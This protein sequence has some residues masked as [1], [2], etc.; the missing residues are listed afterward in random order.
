MQDVGGCEI[1]R[2]LVEETWGPSV[3][4][5]I[6]TPED[7]GD[8]DQPIFWLLKGRLFLHLKIVSQRVYISHQSK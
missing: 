8:A 6:S 5:I 2:M 4:S 1:Y 7:A 3:I